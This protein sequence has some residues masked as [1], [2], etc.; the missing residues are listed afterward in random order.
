MESTH[1]IMKIL[2]IWAHIDQEKLWA[3][4]IEIFR[5]YYIKVKNHLFKETTNTNILFAIQLHIASCF[6]K[7]I[8]LG[9]LDGWNHL[10]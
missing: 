5:F 9:V 3:P 7:G 8:T 1:K 6:Q 4:Y 10:I 2:K